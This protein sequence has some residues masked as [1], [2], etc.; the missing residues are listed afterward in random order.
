MTARDLELQAGDTGWMALRRRADVSTQIDPTDVDVDVDVESDNEASGLAQARMTRRRFAAL[1]VLAVGAIGATSLLAACGDD[2]DDAPPAQPGTTPAPADDDEDDDEDDEADTDDEPQRGGRVVTTVAADADSLNPHRSFNAWF[3]WYNM[4][5][6]LVSMNMDLEFEPNLA[7]SWEISDDGLEYTLELR[8]GLLF[9]DGTPINAEAVQYTNERAAEPESAYWFALG[10][11]VTEA[12]DDNTVRLTL[13]EPYSALMYN[14]QDEWSAVLSKDAYEERGEDFGRNPV[15]SGP[16]KFKEWVPN[17][18]I[19]LERFDD[20]QDFRSYTENEGPPHVDELVFRVIPDLQTRIS[21]FEAGEVNIVELPG[22]QAER[23]E[24]DDDF[25]VFK[26]LQGV[27]IN[28]VMFACI[29]MDGEVDFVPPVDEVEV[30]QAVAYAMNVEDII[31]G[32]WAGNAQRNYGILPH[33]S[34][35]YNPDIEEFGYHHDPDRARELLDQAGWVEGSGNFRQRDG[36]TLTLVIGSLPD[37][38]PQRIAQLIQNQLQAVGIDAQLRT[39]E[40][41][42]IREARAAGEMHL[43]HGSYGWGDQDIVYWLANDTSLLAGHYGLYNEE[44]QNLALEGW[45]VTDESERAE[46]YF[47]ATKI[48]LADAAIIPTFTTVEVAGSRSE[49]R[50]FKLGPQ[51]KYVYSDV[52]IED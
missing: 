5:D 28:Y 45:A 41:A 29:D 32:V 16:F 23:F 37:S 17:E 6:T 7:E 30:R 26:N 19:T 49:V 25:E 48:A 13:P 10:G 52:Q 31:T 35:G 15:G 20:Y 44:F 47:E 34:A 18:R 4:Y 46:I 11:A 2:E 9:H 27:R 22:Q 40:A 42:V 12:I 39:V 50:G 51:G 38:T 3:V 21:A 1:S 43:E 24:N 36:E 14:L 33:G 8:E